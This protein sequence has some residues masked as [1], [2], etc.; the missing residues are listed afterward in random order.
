MQQ[1]VLEER[2]IMVEGIQEFKNALRQPLAKCPWC[3]SVLSPNDRNALKREVD[4]KGATIEDEC[5]IC[6]N[7][8]Q[9][10]SVI[11]GARYCFFAN[12]KHALNT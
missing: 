3:N 10:I 7:M 8:I 9:A 12:K 6:F 4:T 2:L 11:R 1:F 5:R